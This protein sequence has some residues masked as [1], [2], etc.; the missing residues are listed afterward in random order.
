MLSTYPLSLSGA[1][2]QPLPFI[3]AV[4]EITP[5][6]QRLVDP[7]PGVTGP[8]SV[9]AEDPGTKYTIYSTTG[10]EDESGPEEGDPGPPK[11][12]SDGKTASAPLGTEPLSISNI[13]L[14]YAETTL[15][16][17]FTATLEL[18]PIGFYGEALPKGVTD[19]KAVFKSVSAFAQLDGPLVTLE[20]AE[21]S[22]V[23]GGFGYK[24]ERAFQMI[25]LQAMAV[26]KFGQSINMGLFTVALDDIPTSASKAK[27]G[28]VEPGIAVVV[29]LDYGTP[30]A[31]AQ[32]PPNSY[33]LDPDCHLT[34]GV[35][36]YYLFEAPHC[37]RLLVGDF[38]F[39]LG[40]YHE[41]FG[42]PHG[43]PNRPRVGISWSLSS[44]RPINY[45]IDRLRHHTKGMHG[46]WEAA[47][48]VP[49]GS[50]RGPFDFTAE[51]GVGVGVCFNLD[52]LFVHIHVS[53]EV[54]P[55]WSC[56]RI[57]RSPALVATAVHPTNS[58]RVIELDDNDEPIAIAVEFGLMNDSGVPE[59][60]HNQA[61][62]VWGGTFAFVPGCKMAIGKAEQVSETGE[63]VRYDDETSTEPSKWQQHPQRSSLLD[64]TDGGVSLVMGSLLYA[65]PP[66][67]AEDKQQTFRIL[68]ADWS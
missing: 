66:F 22:G 3:P 45:K 62:T 49:P 42:M 43:F 5:R 40:G 34:S 48:G 23:T 20:F 46:H 33:I 21:I 15:H 8:L 18:G 41:A 37:D 53:V 17:Q 4:L 63:P 2:A 30:K 51:A 68:D 16:I 7:V 44:A 64:S 26:V 1:E 6:Q 24:S 12:D 32:L 57:Y 56:V 36:L 14:K 25:S 19:P 67:M 55:S 59:R 10:E 65:P 29:D 58:P 47:C 31:E 9:V 13:G 54:V 50:D 61:W 52:I 11:S 60:G 38:V 35:P 39:T 27:F 28:H